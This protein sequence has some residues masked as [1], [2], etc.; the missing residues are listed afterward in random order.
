MQGYLQPLK[1]LMEK[2]R[3]PE[4]AIPMKRYMQNRFEFLGIKRAGVQSIFRQ[5]VRSSGAPREDETIPVVTALWAENEREYQYCGLDILYKSVKKAE[6]ELLDF[7]IEL[8]EAKSWWDTVDMLAQKCV[9]IMLHRFPDMIKPTVNR[10]QS[11]SNIWLNRTAL[12]FQNRYRDETDFPLLCSIIGQFSFSSEFF[13]QKAI[14]WA[15]REYAKTNPEAVLDFLNSHTVSSLSRR[16]A[17]KKI[18]S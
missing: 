3:N 5:F 6:P 15:L 17:L 7:L 13:L 14:G 10:L 4:D 11:S 16:E 8:T 12:L 18:S 1:D 2:G 9:G